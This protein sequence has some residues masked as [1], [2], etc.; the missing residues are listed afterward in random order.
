MQELLHCANS[1]KGWAAERATIA[2]Q[3][4]EALQNGQIGQAEARE[5]LEDLVRADKLDAEAD[6]LQLKTLLVTGIYAIIQVC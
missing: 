5:L 3:I 6:D 1:G 2:L 4:G